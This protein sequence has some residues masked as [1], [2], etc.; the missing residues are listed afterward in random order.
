MAQHTTIDEVKDVAADAT[1]T[2]TEFGNQTSDRVVA[3]VKEASAKAASLTADTQKTLGVN[4]E[5]FSK[6]L[7]GVSAFNQH[8]LEA[9]SKSSEIAGKAFEGI[10]REVAAY[11]KTSLEERVA[12]VQDL[13]TSKTLSEL[14]EKQTAFARSAFEGWMQQAS[15]MSEIYTAAAKDIA[16]PIGQ[17]FSAAAEELKA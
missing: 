12:A 14:F 10:G 9:F 5:D 3:S 6:R 1:K 11:A 16:A 2:V 7:Q 17:R 8:T 13:A 4:V 15:K